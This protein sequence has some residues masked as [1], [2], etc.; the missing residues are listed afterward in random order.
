[1]GPKLSEG[2]LNTRFYRWL[3][4]CSHCGSTGKTFHFWDKFCEND[5][6]FLYFS[7]TGFELRNI[8]ATFKYSLG[9][10]ARL[11]VK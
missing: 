7:K 2:I 6:I 9:L 11:L 5:I 1:M 4:C 10:R 3:H 8:E